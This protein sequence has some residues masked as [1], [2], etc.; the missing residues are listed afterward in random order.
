ME[1]QA[2]LQILSSVNYVALRNPKQVSS[3]LLGRD[4]IDLD[5]GILKNEFCRAEIQG[6]V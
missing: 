4:G 3:H 6:I 5:T 2:E 1:S